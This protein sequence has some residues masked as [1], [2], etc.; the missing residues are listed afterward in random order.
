[1]QKSSNIYEKNKSTQNSAQLSKDNDSEKQLVHKKIIQKWRKNDMMSVNY[2]L[3]TMTYDKNPQTLR[4]NQLFVCNVADCKKSFRKVCSLKDHLKIHNN[5]KPYE[6]P[7]CHK[8]F[9]QL[10]TCTRHSGNKQCQ[11]RV[12]RLKQDQGKQ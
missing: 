5:D 8:K 10:G 6:C 4:M 12:L 2:G 3:Y 7:K 1:M 11:A 9:S